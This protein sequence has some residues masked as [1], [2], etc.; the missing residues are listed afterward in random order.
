MTPARRSNTV[1]A[2]VFVRPKKSI[3]W[4]RSGGIVWN[5]SCWKWFEILFGFIMIRILNGFYCFF[6]ILAKLRT[7][8]KD[9]DKLLNNFFVNCARC[10]FLQMLSNPD[11]LL[12]CYS[13]KTFL[14]EICRY[15]QQFF[16]CNIIP[17]KQKIFIICSP[18]KQ[19]RGRRRWG[20]GSEVRY[21]WHLLAHIV[22]QNALNQHYKCIHFKQ[23]WENHLC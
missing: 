23:S 22:L 2:P 18:L 11:S 15:S 12:I 13:T 8:N 1:L 14:N 20:G 19:L 17:L 5:K 3:Y 16:G 6:T 10:F 9:R 7:I 21:M 4:S